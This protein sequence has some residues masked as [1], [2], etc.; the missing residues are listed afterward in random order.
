MEI[1][2]AINA[3]VLIYFFFIDT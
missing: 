1:K 3:K 2:N